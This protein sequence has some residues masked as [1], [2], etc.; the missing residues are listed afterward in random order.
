MLQ[1]L[2]RSY[3]PARPPKQRAQFCQMELSHL[4][5]GGGQEAAGVD[6]EVTFFCTQVPLMMEPWFNPEPE[7]LNAYIHA[8]GRHNNNVF[9]LD[10]YRKLSD[11][12]R[13]NW[14][15]NQDNKL[16]HPNQEKGAPL[17]NNLVNLAVDFCMQYKQETLTSSRLT[18]LRA[19]DNYYRNTNI[20][21]FNNICRRKFQKLT[22]KELKD[23]VAIRQPLSIDEARQT[24]EPLPDI[25]PYV[26]EYEA[27]NQQPYALGEFNCL[28]APERIPRHESYHSGRFHD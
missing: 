7:Q 28:V 26:A 25:P 1:T 9:V 16:L 12:I 10:I 3:D 22:K 20:W 14:E 24:D 13:E 21:D 8:Y 4:L 6:P 11:G 27:S 18:S 5:D 2:V 23:S 17:M 19:E 15:A